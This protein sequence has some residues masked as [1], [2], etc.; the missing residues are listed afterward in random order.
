[1]AVSVYGSTRQFNA[2]FRE[3]LNLDNPERAEAAQRG[4]L[5]DLPAGGIIR[6]DGGV[7]WDPAWFG[8]LDEDCPETVNPS[9]WHHAQ[10]NAYGGLFE[11]T[12]GVWQ[13]RA[14]DY[15][16]MSII[17]GESGWIIVDPI[18][19]RE[20]A[21]A[22]L[23]LV[24]DTLGHRRVSAVLVTH[25]HADH[26]GGLGGVI[27][28]G[29]SIPLYVPE[30]FMAYAAAEGVL[31]GNH[32][33]RRAIDQFGLAL[34]FGPE[35]LVDGGIGKTLAR[36]Y[37]GFREPTH[38]IGENDRSVR[39]DGVTFEFLM[40]SGTEAPAEFAFFLPE[41]AVLC[42]AEVCTQ[43]QHNLLTPRGAEVRD[44][45]LWARVIDEALIRFGDR[46][47]ILINSHNW[48]VW[49]QASARTFLLEQRDIYKYI[50]D[51]TLRLANQGMTIKEVG[52]ALQ[53]PDFA[54]E[55]LHVRGYYGMLSFNARAVYQKYYGAFDGRPVD[56][57]PLPPEAEGQRYVEALGGVGRVLELAREAVA[58]DDLQWAATL[59]NHVVFAGDPN[60]EAR[61]LLSEIYRN[62]AYRAESG[63]ERNICLAGAQEL[64]QGVKILPAAGGRNAE[65]A[66]TLSLQDWLD[67][68]AIRLNPERAR[69]EAFSVLLH[70][71]EGSALVSIARQTE[72]ARI[73]A[74]ATSGS[75]ADVTVTATRAALE[76][77]MNGQPGDISVVGDADA[78]QRWLDMHD[79]FDL[80]FEIATP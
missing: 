57:N 36:G 8:F 68:Y 31:G 34:P 78:F 72:F 80:W 44:A 2:R 33:S 23:A 4:K 49:G 7:A 22:A 6:P 56:L 19:T 37:R 71:P 70:L 42:M 77:R 38:E 54:R 24:N 29:E 17:E 79:H 64:E 73:G 21:Q 26:F 39:I 40:A 16:N 12:K 47:Q 27:G 25:T 55:A 1:M 53:E 75:Q 20:S 48:P 46:T 15:A 61:G 66:A 41:H 35:G 67:A 58:Q 11:V 45:R 10:L 76:A 18:L 28:E 30:D 65:L 50:H 60:P 3:N 63:I 14:A 32:T 5:A 52:Q 62:M 74:P 9:L 43:T 51:Q 59:L 69:G 13:V